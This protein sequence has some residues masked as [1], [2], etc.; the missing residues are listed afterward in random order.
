MKLIIITSPTPVVGEIDILSQITDIGVHRIHLRR[1]NCTINE[2]RKILSALPAETVKHIMLHDYH[3]LAD[4]FS[5]AGLHINNRNPDSL[6]EGYDGELSRSCHSLQEVEQYK[7]EY[8]YLF[9][10]PIFDS[11]SKIGYQGAFSSESL[12]NARISGIIDEKVVALG[13]VTLKKIPLLKEWSFG[14]AALLGDFW[15][16]ILRKEDW[17]Y[18]LKSFLHESFNT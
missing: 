6:K 4:E 18:Y 10:S 17:K 3:E 13:G 15:N 12:R 8:N 16:R 9:L 14:G 5:I 7:N 2:I 11:I 1:P